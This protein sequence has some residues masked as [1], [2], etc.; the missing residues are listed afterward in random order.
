MTEQEPTTPST[1]GPPAISVGEE[2]DGTIA[3]AGEVVPWV[4]ELENDSTVD[5]YMWSETGSLDTYIYLYEDQVTDTP[6]YQNDDNASA[7][8]SA[9]SNGLITSHVGGRYNSAV[10]GVELAAGTYLM[11][12]GS[13]NNAGTGDY[14]IKVVGNTN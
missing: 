11:V 4:I 10:T 2:V 6:L 12:P 1:D 7:I 8:N 9:V 5:V 14:R 3:T 13:Y